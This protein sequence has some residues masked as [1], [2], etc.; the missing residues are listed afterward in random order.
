MIGIIIVMAV[1]AWAL[2]FAAMGWQAVVMGA[3][4]L[5][6]AYVIALA[7]FVYVIYHLI[8][9]RTAHFRRDSALR[10]GL[11]EWLKARGGGEITTEIATMNLIHSDGLG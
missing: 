8:K 10:A 7:S 2:V 9:R 4:S 6:V 1:M 5:V 3:A 11:I